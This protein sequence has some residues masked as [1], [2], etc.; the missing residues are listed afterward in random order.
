[1]RNQIASIGINQSEETYLLAPK[2]LYKGEPLWH[3]QLRIQLDPRKLLM[4]IERKFTCN[5]FGDVSTFASSPWWYI[6]KSN[7]PWNAFSVGFPEIAICKVK[8]N[9]HTNLFNLSFFV[10]GICHKN[11]LCFCEVRHKKRTCRILSNYY[12]SEISPLC[13]SI[14]PSPQIQD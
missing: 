14:I 4:V 6:C 7:H 2:S 10:E 1:M 3:L 8:T 9:G 13:I 12:R 5:G 11:P